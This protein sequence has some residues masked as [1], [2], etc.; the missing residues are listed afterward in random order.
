MNSGKVVLGVLAGALLGVLFAPHRGS[1]TRKKIARKG[2]NVADG[3]KE[4]LNEFLEV[5]TEKFEKVKD[6]V[7]EFTE[8][9]LAKAEEA[10]KNTQNA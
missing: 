6:D 3:V 9:K 2:G 8:E 10:K 5:I 1:V 4:K 7:V